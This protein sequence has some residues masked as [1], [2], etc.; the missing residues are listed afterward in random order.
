MQALKKK[1]AGHPL[2]LS[3]L[4]ALI[5][6][7][8]AGVLI[9]WFL[10]SLDPIEKTALEYVN[11][12]YVHPDPKVR[13]YTTTDFN[14]VNNLGQIVKPGPVHIGKLESGN[15]EQMKVVV[16]FD[17]PKMTIQGSRLEI[18]MRLEDGEWKVARDQFRGLDMTFEMFQQ[19]EDYIKEGI[20]KW[21]K[22]ELPR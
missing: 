21:K 1:W 19:T 20:S 22:A 15:E 2:R 9:W 16:F 5:V 14:Q 10:N 4:I 13:N 6:I 17:D 3:L 11:Y 8:A 7:V 12:N 18:K